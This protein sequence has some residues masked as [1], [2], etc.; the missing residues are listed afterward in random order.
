MQVTTIS[1]GEVSKRKLEDW[2]GGHAP[3][4][5]RYAEIEEFGFLE[6]GYRDIVS[7]RILRATKRGEYVESISQVQSGIAWTALK[8]VYVK[9]ARDSDD[10]TYILFGC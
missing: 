4:G 1:L 2:Q 5:E 8:F 6:N 7:D 3:V 10:Y 9:P